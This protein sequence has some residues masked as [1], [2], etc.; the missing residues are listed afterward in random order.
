ME[1]QGYAAAAALARMG[2]DVPAAAGGDPAGFHDHF[3]MPDAG[4]YALAIGGDD[5][6]VDVVSSNPGHLLGTPIV[7]ERHAPLVADRL[8]ADDLWTP[9]GIRPH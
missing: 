3:W 1:V 9:A 2:V 8:F 6:R 7:D 5:R 4:T